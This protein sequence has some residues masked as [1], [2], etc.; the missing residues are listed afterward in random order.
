VKHRVEVV[1]LDAGVV[2]GEAPVDGLDGGVAVG[3]PGCDL[4]FE[5]G[6]VWQA[7]VEAL[8]GEDAQFDLSEPM[9]VHLL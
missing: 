1:E 4:V 6:A 8:A 2:G 5:G 7:S 9:L 3:D